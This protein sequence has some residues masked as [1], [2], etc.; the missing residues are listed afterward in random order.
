M[1]LSENSARPEFLAEQHHFTEEHSHLGEIQFS[2]K[3]KYHMKLV[4]YIYIIIYIH[5]YTYIHIHIHIIIYNYKY[6]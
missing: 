1:G 3:A 2:D 5:I 4:G 6:I